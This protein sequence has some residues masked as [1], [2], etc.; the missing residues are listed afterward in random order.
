MNCG[1]IGLPN[2]GKSSL[3][4]L[5]TGDNAPSS[6]YPYC[7][8]EPNLGIARLKD[9]RMEKLRQIFPGSKVTYPAVEFVDIAGL[10]PGASKGEG[11]GNQFLSAIRNV[12]GIVHVVRAFKSGNVSRFD[13]KSSTPLQD[14]KLVE[15]ELFLSDIEIVQRRLKE[16]PDSEY[17]NG[18]L[19]KLERE[20][21][22]GPDKEGVLLTPKPQIIL[23]NI[24]TGG[25]RPDIKRENVIYLDVEFQKELLNMDSR[26]RKEFIDTLPADEAVLENV[27]EKVKVMLDQVTF[28][29]V[30]GGEE[31]KGY[32]VKRGTTV[33]TGAGKVHTDMEKNFIK[34][35]VFNYS[36]FKKTKFSLPRLKNK[37][38]IRTVGRDYIVQDGDILE[39]MFGKN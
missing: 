16:D 4:N 35:R 22:P 5:L 7:T 24:S 33:T 30:T 27:L 12:Y 1:I 34:A 11:L 2:V 36:D 8:V 29:T 19:K 38:L 10:P 15:T 13:S 26:E 3:F 39:I 28:F 17:Y 32:N 9:S 20:I 31:L 6:N 21:P 37:G 18:A 14:L 23:V 25:E